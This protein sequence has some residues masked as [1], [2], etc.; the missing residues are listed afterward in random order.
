MKKFFRILSLTFATGFGSGYLP[1]APGSWG[2]AVALLGSWW[3][4]DLSIVWYVF[5]IVV[6]FI[7][8]VAV[9]RSAD[10]HFEKAGGSKSDN[11]QIVIDEWVGMLITLMPLFFFEKTL[12]HLGMAFLLFRIFDAAK[13]GLIEVADRLHNR[14]GVMLD[15]AFA[16]LHAG[17]FFFIALWIMYQ[18]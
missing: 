8:G 2:A 1:W 15:D 16:G 3:L 18:W 9:S 11:S 4:L 10:D 6:L 17:V 13:F 12:L 7:I 5:L 14:W